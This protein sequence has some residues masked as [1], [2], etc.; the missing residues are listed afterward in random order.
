[1]IRVGSPEDH[2]LALAAIQIDGGTQSRANVNDQVVSEYAE[3]IKAGATFP[4]IVVFYDGKKHWLADGFHR[5]HAYQKAG[6]AKVAADVRQGTRRDAILHSVGANETHGLRR[7]R[8][9]K[10]RAV[11]TLLNDAEWGKWTDREIARRCAVSPQTVANVRADTVQNGQ[12][13]ERTYVHPKTGKPTTMKTAGINASRKAGGD[14][15]QE[16]TSQT[17]AQQAVEGGDEPEKPVE[18]ITPAD[19]RTDAERDAYVIQ[20]EWDRASDEGRA[21]FLA[22]NNL[23][24]QP[25]VEAHDAEACNTHS[26]AVDPAS[27]VTDGRANMEP[28]DVDR[29]AER[30]SSAVKVGAPVSPEG[31]AASASSGR[32]EGRKRLQVAREPINAAEPD[33]LAATREGLSMERGIDQCVTGGESAALNYQSDDDAFSEVKGAARPENA[34]GV[35]PSSSDIN[36]PSDATPSDAVAAPQAPQPLKAATAPHSNPQ[37]FPSPEADK[38]EASTSSPSASATN[39]SP[40]YLAGDDGHRGTPSSDALAAGQGESP[41]SIAKSGQAVTNPKPFCLKLKDGHC[42]ISFPTAALCAECNKARASA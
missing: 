31:A 21:L 17:V 24:E 10:R 22:R 34:A 5:F 39:P 40:A 1:M 32:P 19:A 4:P 6:K 16:I 13:D 14:E 38:A 36:S 9:D 42:K 12:S 7:T 28:D 30:A 2:G 15:K 29:S 18:E 33:V 35:E 25:K 41:D 8:D 37:P 26:N 11:L 3:A 27:T 20:W 23:T